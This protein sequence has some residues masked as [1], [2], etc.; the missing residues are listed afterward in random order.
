MHGPGV[1]GQVQGGLA[2]RVAA[3]DD[4][5]VA[6]GHGG[7]LADRGTVEHTAADELLELRDVEPSVGDTRRHHD[8]AGADP[9][10]VG[11]LD[12][13]EVSIG[14]QAHHDP[15]E[16][17]R[18]AE[19]PR[20]LEGP[21]GEL[22]PA[23]ALGEPR[24]VADQG[25]GSGLSADRLLLDDQGLEALG[26][27]VHRGGQPRRSG[28]DDDQVEH[29]VLGRRRGQ[30]E[31]IGDLEVRG[32]EQRGVLGREEQHHDRQ[33]VQSILVRHAQRVE[34]ARTLGGVGVVVADRDVVPAEHVAQLVAARRHPVPDHADRLEPGVVVQVPV[35]ERV[36]DGGVELLVAS[37]LRAD[38]R[39]VGL[40]G[41]DRLE[42]AAG[43]RE[44][45]PFDDDAPLGGRVQLT[46]RAQE[47]DAGLV[48]LQVRAEDQR[49]RGPGL[50]HRFELVGGGCGAFDDPNVVVGPVAG[51]QSVADR[52]S[53]PLVGRGEDDQWGVGTGH[54]APGHE[55]DRR[56]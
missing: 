50:P 49:H 40:P 7:G 4:D 20:L 6:S 42:H 56:R 25:A 39:E 3:A 43:G 33:T 14:G 9:R 45:T 8:G 29:L 47:V 53:G 23:D 11:E 13:S 24:V 55:V 16:Q 48:A 28:P 30:T 26:G 18:G 12:H 46:D 37:A 21:E 52:G 27:G 34:H 5:D 1:L 36:G 44:L 32:V 2:R 35:L 51:A 15:H 19:G 31:G 17:E 38:D 54:G 41:A 22:R 10:S